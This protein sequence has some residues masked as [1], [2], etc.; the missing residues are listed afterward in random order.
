[1]SKN[2]ILAAGVLALMPF[3]S[4]SQTLLDVA[5]NYT[6]ASWT[7]GSDQGTGF[8]AWSLS[9]TGG[10]GRYVGGTGLG[11]NT[12]GIFST[13]TGTSTAIRP[14]DAPLLAGQTFKVQL[15]YTFLNNS[16]EIGLN[17]WSGS[18]WRLNLKFVGGQNNWM[19]ND[20]GAGGAFSSGL[21][22]AGGNPGTA[23]TFEFTRGASGN[24]Y[25]LS[26]TQGSQ[27]YN[28]INNNSNSGTMNVDR[29]EFYSNNQGNGA[30]LGFNNLEI[31][32]EPSSA[33]LLTFA[34]SGLL[35]LRRRRNA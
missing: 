27:T 6:S 28:G 3:S 23:L 35:A 34:L 26:L 24:L 5:S 31:I 9:N 21:T 16:G 15:G 17:L 19:I 25:S 8:G 12:F 2:L 7:N 20:G 32:P 13:D 22:W 11:A 18:N 30:N 33:S 4:F 14:F 1:M 10:G 29:V